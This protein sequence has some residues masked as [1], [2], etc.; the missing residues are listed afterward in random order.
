MDNQLSNYKL[1][2]TYRNGPRFL[3]ARMKNKEGSELVL[4][5]LLQ[6]DNEWTKTGFR[7]ELAFLHWVESLGVSGLSEVFPRL[8]AFEN[9][10]ETVWYATELLKGE[11]QNV[12]P[13]QFLLRGDFNT[14]VTPTALANFLLNLHA[15]TADV[16]EPIQ[17][18]MTASPLEQYAGFLEWEK[19]F[20]PSTPR[21]SGK[22]AAA[23]AS[24]IGEDAG[25]N[26]HDGWLDVRIQPKIQRFLGEHA[27]VYD[28][29]QKVLT[30]F[31][32][33]GAHILSTLEGDL[34]IIDWENIG[35]SDPTHDFTTIYLRAYHFPEWQ[36][37]FLS[38]FR[39]GLP[40]DF[41]IDSVWPVELVLQSLGNLRR[42]AET[43]L[44]EELAEKDDAV[45]YFRQTLLTNL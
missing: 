36:D 19:L 5:K 24:R 44:R 1:I 41:P 7:K 43:T 35:L 31:E 13:S 22:V 6:M 39:A 25:S 27:S 2:A 42:F 23:T 21:H 12:E 8:L 28:R 30:H 17:E 40:D 3:V 33:Y 10:K 34:K 16:P 26:Q 9:T 29:Q 18:G 32:F 4:K 37:E 15:V 14:S 38:I 45:E 20:S 11:F